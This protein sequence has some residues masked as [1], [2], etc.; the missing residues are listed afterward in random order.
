MLTANV[1]VSIKHFV[2]SPQFNNLRLSTETLSE[3]CQTSTIK[4]FAEITKG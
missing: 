1:I 4:R 3:P 2:P